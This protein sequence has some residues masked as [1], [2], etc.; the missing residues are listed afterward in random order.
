MKKLKDIVER[1]DTKEGKIFDLFIQFFIVLSLITFSIDTLPD[2]SVKIRKVLRLFEVITVSIFSIEYFLRVL[3]ADK[4]IRFI[5]SFFG[6]IDLLA[7]LPF[8]LRLGIDLRSIRSIRMLRIFRM[9]KLARYSRAIHRLHRALNII[10]QELVLFFATTCILLYLSAAG[11]YLFENTAQPEAF[12]SVFHSLW[13]AT[14]TLTTV[15][16]GDIYPVTVG[17]KIFTFFVLMI[18]LGIVAVPTGLMAS[19]LSKAREEE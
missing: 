18:G 14:I 12:K 5:F 10:K 9:L 8:Y 3:V 17:G 19:A 4:K 1:N 2:L 6:I 7:I 11:I 15:G 16:Y 13:W